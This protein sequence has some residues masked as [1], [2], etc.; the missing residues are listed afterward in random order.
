MK[1]VKIDR[2]VKNI[3]DIFYEQDKS[4]AQNDILG[5]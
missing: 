3:L 1:I 5:G 4:L 2:K